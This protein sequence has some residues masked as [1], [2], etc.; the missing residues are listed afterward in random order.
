MEPKV[1]VI[2]SNRNNSELVTKS[3]ANLEEIRGKYYPNLEV[4]VVDKESSDGSVK[5][6]EERFPWVKVI[7]SKD[8]GLAAASNLGAK[9]ATGEYLLFLSPDGYPRIDTIGKLVAYMQEHPEVGIASPRLSLQ[10]G[11]PDRDASRSFPTPWNSFTKLT[12]LSSLFPKSKLFSSYFKKFDDIHVPYET[13]ACVM[14]FMMIPSA[15]YA[16]VGGFDEDYFAFGQD[17]DICYRMKQAG[18]KVMFLPQWES[19][20]LKTRLNEK[21]APF[22]EKLRLAQSSTKAMR[23]F[24][25]KNYKNKY[26]ASMIA[27]MMLGTYII[28]AQRV[29]VLFLKQMFTNK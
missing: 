15:T 4:I 10:G 19:G 25:K 26:S 13:D 27:F 12:G 28:E 17:L 8:L 23:L 1:S 24:L 2:I 7:K 22:A 14:D 11:V 20:H 6:Y 18:Y 29:G 16:K 9:Q 3:L 21:R 5:L